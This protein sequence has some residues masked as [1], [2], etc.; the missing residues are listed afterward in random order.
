MGK[1][2]SGEQKIGDELQE[3]ASEFGR[4]LWTW[5]TDFLPHRAARIEV[6]RNTPEEFTI[7]LY[8]E[9]HRYRIKATKD[10]LGCIMVNRKPHPGETWLR[11]Q[12]LPDGRFSKDTLFEIL[13]SIVFNELEEIT[14]FHLLSEDMPIKIEKS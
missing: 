8:T 7:R 9:K 12:D 14:Q 4:E 13:S 6:V 11:G 10:Y 5:L 3:I 1:L 2:I